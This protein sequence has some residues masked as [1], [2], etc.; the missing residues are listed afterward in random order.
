MIK[1]IFK[2]IL[3]ILVVCVSIAI[4]AYLIFVSKFADNK[5]FDITFKG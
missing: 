4:F 2:I 1:K 5:Y 3:W